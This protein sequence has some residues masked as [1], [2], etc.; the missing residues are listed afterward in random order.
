MAKDQGDIL[1]FWRQNFP[2]W[3]EKKYGWFYKSNPYGKSACLIARNGKNDDMIGSAVFFPRQV[4]IDGHTQLVGITADFGIKK[5]HRAFGPAISLQKALITT[6]REDRLGFLY[7]FPNIHAELPKKRAGFETLGQTIRLVRILKYDH[8]IDR[9]IGWR[10]MARV[11]SGILNTMYKTL[12]WENFYGRN[13][14][15][16]FEILTAFDDRFNR[17]WREASPAYKIIGERTADYLNW[18]FSQ[19]PYQTYK[20]FALTDKDD[21]GI[22]GY[23]VYQVIDKHAYIADLFAFKAGHKLD[24][25]L[26][27]YLLY[28]RNQEIDSVSYV[29]FGDKAIINKFKKYNFIKRD[30]ARRIMVY[31][32]RQSPYLNCLLDKN[33][34]HLMEGDND[35]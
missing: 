18:R 25:L 16:K 34:W 15:F 13:R 21:Q 33:N 28:I 17:L 24:T 35:I 32:D 4:I 6:S 30:G 12:T 23:I 7:G 1:E 11:F 8:Y 9:I 31:I 29:Y 2:A 26:S 3:P 5:E 20:I 19:C 10:L 14:K 27:K 22:L